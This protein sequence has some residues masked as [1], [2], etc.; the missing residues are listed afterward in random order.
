MKFFKVPFQSNDDESSGDPRENRLYHYIQSQ[1]PEHMARL[2]SEINPDVRQIISSNV[3]AL[4]GYLPSQEFSTTV[5]SSKENLQN[6]LASAMLTGYFVKTMENRMG[7]ESLFQDTEPETETSEATDATSPETT[8]SEVSDREAS[9]AES[10][11]D[12]FIQDE[13]EAADMSPKP[14]RL[15]DVKLSD[16]RELFGNMERQ[17]DPGQ[18]A[19]ERFE[20]WAAEKL[21]ADALNSASL[22]RFLSGSEAPGRRKST[23]GDEPEK[24]NIQVEINTRMDKGE[25]FDLLRGLREVQQLQQQAPESQT[26]PF[27]A[28]P[29]EGDKHPEDDVNLGFDFDI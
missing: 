26:E 9:D 21:G 5:M 15:E 19:R 23:Q 4:L 22:E 27:Q 7:M 8:D 1:S 14:P 29:A 13:L 11:E 12:G 16:P 25:L 2:A 20:R 3:Q 24:L 28:P 6:L 18:S 17:R 10:Q